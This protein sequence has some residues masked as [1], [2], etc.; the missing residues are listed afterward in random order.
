MDVYRQATTSLR[1]FSCSQQIVNIL[2]ATFQL[3]FK[4]SPSPT[5][6]P[7]SSPPAV[8]DPAAPHIIALA[9]DRICEPAASPRALAFTVT[10]EIFISPTNNIRTP[11]GLTVQPASPC[12]FKSAFVWDGVVWRGSPSARVGWH[13]R[14]LGGLWLAFVSLFGWTWAG[15]GL[16]RMGLCWRGISI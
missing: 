4:P 7:P 3:T 1:S 13:G 8:G 14:H 6:P 2:A 12:P 9:A 10:V 16:I 15:V 5:P 11:S